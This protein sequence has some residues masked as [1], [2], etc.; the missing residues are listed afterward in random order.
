M[1]YTYMVTSN[2]KRYPRKYLTLVQ[3]IQNTCMGIYKS[4]MYANRLSLNI[5]AEKEQR[6]S[7]QTKVICDCDEL[8]C[9]IQLSF[10]LNL[11]GNDTS[12]HWQQRIS[13][14]KY[15]VIA[16]RSKDKRR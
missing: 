16:W 1:K 13:D 4:L 2:H 8:S 15:M 9:F 12:E 7:L 11:I 5:E 6:I 14:I 10:E 3:E